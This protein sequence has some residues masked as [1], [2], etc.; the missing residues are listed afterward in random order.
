MGS[1]TPLATIA[2]AVRMPVSFLSAG[3]RHAQ[4]QPAFLR[5]HGGRRGRVEY[6]LRT[7]HEPAGDIRP[8][9]GGRKTLSARRKGRGDPRARHGAG[10]GTLSDGIRRPPRGS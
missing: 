4:R 2:P 3:S 5:R 1:E 7:G 10:R 8:T 6:E 9:G